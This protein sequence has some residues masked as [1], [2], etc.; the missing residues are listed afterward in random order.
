MLGYAWPEAGVNDSNEECFVIRLG[1]DTS[2]LLLIGRRSLE[3]RP[4]RHACSTRSP[5]G[6]DKRLRFFQSCFPAMA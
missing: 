3:R 2:F 5:K 6:R 4:V 1:S